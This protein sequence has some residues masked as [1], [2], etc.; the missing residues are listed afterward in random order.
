[1]VVK[2]RKR[3][4]VTQVEVEIRQEDDSLSNRIIDLVGA[5]HDGHDLYQQP[6]FH[7]DNEIYFWP[8][9]AH[10]WVTYRPA[11]SRAPY[12]G[13]RARAVGAISDTPERL[14]G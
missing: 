11:P 13:L 7:I 5:G 9:G 12:V 10:G 6:Y 4:S 14:A 2:I 1:M 3:D 8:R